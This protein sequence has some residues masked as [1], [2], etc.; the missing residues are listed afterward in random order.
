MMPFR[1]IFILS[2]VVA[3]LSSTSGQSAEQTISDE[4]YSGLEYAISLSQSADNLE[5][6]K[7]SELVEF[8][9]NTPADSSAA[10]KEKHDSEGAFHSF[11]IKGDLN[12]IIDYVY[13]PDI[14]NYI[15]MPSSL[16]AHKWLTPE[17]KDALRQLPRKVESTED[18]RLLRGQEKEA[19]TPDTNTGGYYSY[20]Q[21]RALAIFP[22]PA[23]PVIVSISSQSDSSDVGRKGCVV[24]D[25]KNWNYLYSGVTGLNKTGMGWVDSYMYHARS[26]L[27]YVTD[28]SKDTVRV[29][30]F[31]WLNAGWAKI[32]M[33]KSN[34]I[35]KGIKRF[36]LDFK[37]VLET[38]GMPEAP[39]LA[40]KYKELMHYEEQKLRE[41]VSP[42]LDALLS[43]GSSAVCSNPFKKQLVSGEYLQRMGRDEMV[44]ILLLEYVKGFLGKEVLVLQNNQVSPTD[45]SDKLSLTYSSTR[46]Q[47]NAGSIR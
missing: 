1:Y 43:F 39:I 9:L 37:T 44:R 13:N 7:F 3:L 24:G 10:L 38:P 2:G 33:V 20:N 46:A 45:S 16:R 27:V 12:H 14:P 35:L 31:K 42:Y 29:G 28:S 11:S 18:I 19:I 34:H 5:P 4:V 32:N 25:D 36:A 22:G 23:G 15:A 26:V 6:E 41:M 17:T 30:S 40:S 8:V 47:E 21:I